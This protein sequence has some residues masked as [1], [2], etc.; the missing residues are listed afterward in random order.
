MVV[1]KT[2]AER[3]APARRSDLVESPQDL[4]CPPPSVGHPGRPLLPL[5][6]PPSPPSGPGPGREKQPDE[7]VKQAKGL[8]GAR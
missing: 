6:P 1:S 2:A 8:I 7:A 4:R 5:P 3:K